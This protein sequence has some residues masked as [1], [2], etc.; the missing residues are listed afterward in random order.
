MKLLASISAF[1][2]FSV[3]ITY[4]GNLHGASTPDAATDVSGVAPVLARVELGRL[5][6]AVPRTR[7]GR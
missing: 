3:G 4:E 6:D 7:I 1:L 2:F 5:P